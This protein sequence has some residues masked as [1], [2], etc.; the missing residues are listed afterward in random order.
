[1]RRGCGTVNCDVSDLSAV[2]RRQYKISL[3]HKVYRDA[4][5]KAFV[6]MIGGT[7]LWNVLMLSFDFL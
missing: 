2:I 7:V 4:K 6:I 1:M 3:V 5:H